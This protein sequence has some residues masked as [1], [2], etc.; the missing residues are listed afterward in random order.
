M[1]A[2]GVVVGEVL[3][4]PFTFRKRL[5][6]GQ[7]GAKLDGVLWPTFFSLVGF[8]VALISMV[9]AKLDNDEPVAMVD[10]FEVDSL[11]GLLVVDVIGSSFTLKLNIRLAQSRMSLTPWEGLEVTQNCLG[12]Y[13]SY[14]AHLEMGGTV[15]RIGGGLGGKVGRRVVT[16][17]K[18]VDLF[19]LDV[20]IVTV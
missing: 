19:R 5:V 9:G 12:L 14:G 4:I 10:D 20:S 17:G 6:D 15:P 3:F 2:V 8:P 13:R 16:P 7:F 1:V 11:M 18:T